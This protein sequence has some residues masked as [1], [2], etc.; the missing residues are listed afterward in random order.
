MYEIHIL[1]AALILH[2]NLRY[3]ILILLKYSSIK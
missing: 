3:L 2:I 1:Q